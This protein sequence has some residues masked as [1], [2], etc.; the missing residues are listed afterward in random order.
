[1]LFFS[2][3]VHGCQGS[4]TLP[5][6]SLQ[7]VHAPNTSSP[8]RSVRPEYSRSIIQYNF[9][10]KLHTVGVKTIGV[11]LLT[12]GKPI[13]VTRPLVGPAFPGFLYETIPPL[14]AQSSY[15]RVV[16]KDSHPPHSLSFHKIPKRFYR[17]IPSSNLSCRRN[18]RAFNN[19]F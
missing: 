7:G 2:F 17:F 14:P 8:L 4:V 19:S 18:N 9:R 6:K 5:S 1:V 3:E 15:L 11:C 10:L 12:A 16:P 13:Y